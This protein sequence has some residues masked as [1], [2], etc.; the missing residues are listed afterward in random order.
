MS[1]TS[2]LLTLVLVL[3]GV[4]VDDVDVDGVDGVDVVGVGV[5]V[6]VDGVDVDVDGVD[7]AVDEDASCLLVLDGC[8]LDA[9]IRRAAPACCFAA[10]WS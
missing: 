5:A 10:C 6:D 8:L 7:V 4:D 3:D 2:S 1:M 9:R